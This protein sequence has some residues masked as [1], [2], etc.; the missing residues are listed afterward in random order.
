MN[1]FRRSPRSKNEIYKNILEVLRLNG[2][3][4]ITYIMYK[5]NVNNVILKQYLKFLQHKKY[6][7]VIYVSVKKGNGRGGN[8]YY[9]T[10]EGIEALKILKNADRIF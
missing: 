1:N 7:S 10:E 4:K 9:I 3:L 5:S 6:V 2:P 8:R